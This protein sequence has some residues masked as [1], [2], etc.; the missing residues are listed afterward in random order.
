[1]RSILCYGDS[2]TYGYVPV[3]KTRYEKQVRWPGKMESMLG[4][5]YQ[6]VEEGLCGRTLIYDCPGMPEAFNG[7]FF[8]ETCLYTH[9]PI[10]LIIIM[11]G[12]N[13]L[14]CVPNPNPLDLSF[15]IEQMICTIK[16]KLMSIE[17]Y[18]VPEILIVSPPALGDTASLQ[19]QGTDNNNLAAEVC[20]QLPEEFK[21]VADYYG[22]HFLKASDFA[23]VS[24]G[25]GVHLDEEGH[26]LLAKAMFDK[27]TSI[28]ASNQY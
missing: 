24:N 27:V 28:F 19:P 26:S 22:C 16:K 6:V 21:K 11:L 2:N 7:Q 8:L 13:D 20:N 3:Q 1:M 14:G 5:G 9:S 25:D 18:Q 15:G 10:D 23:I 4:C 12:T 17:W